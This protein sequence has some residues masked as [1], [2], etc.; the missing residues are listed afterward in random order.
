MISLQVLTLEVPYYYLRSN[1]QVMAALTR[2]V[3]PRRPSQP[4]VSDEYWEF[5]N[6]CWADY[7]SGKRPNITQVSATINA[8]FLSSFDCLLD[9]DIDNDSERDPSPARWVV[10]DGSDPESEPDPFV[11]LTQTDVP[12]L[13]ELDD[14]VTEKFKRAARFEEKF[15]RRLQTSPTLVYL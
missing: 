3:R 6:L 4:P 5:I 10:V 14:A 7:D 9:F 13:W 11:F 15:S 1:M 2:G 8:F 12:S